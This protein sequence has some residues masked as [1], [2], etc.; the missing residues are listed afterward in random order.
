MIS[1]SIVNSLIDLIVKNAAWLFSG[2]G[3]AIVVGLARYLYPRLSNIHLINPIRKYYDTLEKKCSTWRGL[4]LGREVN[5]E[6]IYVSHYIKTP[7]GGRKEIISENEFRDKTLGRTNQNHN[8]LIEGSAGS[9]KTTFLKHLTS[10]L[11]HSN[12]KTS[13]PAYI[14]IL[15]SL[16]DV[17]RAI[18]AENTISLSLIQLAT[19]HFKAICGEIP[20][21]LEDFLS[22]AVRQGKIIILL[23]A[24]DEVPNESKSVIKNWIDNIRVSMK[25]PII[26]TSRPHEIIH[27]VQGFQSYSIEPF[28]S[29]Q[30]NRFI[31]TWF[32][33]SAKPKSQEFAATMITLLRHS[34][35]KYPPSGW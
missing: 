21:K 32:K 23:D 16:N 19:E 34:K 29:K 20:P 18:S 27:E 12:S 35:S 30:Q 3:A 17:S 2:L 1:L 28:N 5:L 8:F 15:L 11:I 26:I 33:G 7:F 13:I 9:G 31:T 14:P 6:D 4:G 10:H 22:R 24:L 25:C